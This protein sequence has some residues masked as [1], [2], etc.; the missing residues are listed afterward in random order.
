MLFRSLRGRVVQLNPWDLIGKK[1]VA[2][3]K[4]KTAT[5]QFVSRALTL[6]QWQHLVEGLSIDG[7]EQERRLL[8][9]LWLGFGCGLRAAEML[10]LTMASLVPSRDAWQLRVLGKGSK[11]RTVPLPSPARQALLAYL[12]SVGVPYED[13]VRLALEDSVDSEAPILRGMRGRRRRIRGARHSRLQPGGG[14]QQRH[15]REK[16]RS[17]MAHGC[18]PVRACVPSAR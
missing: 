3:A 10:S 6:E 15:A 16:H 5:E 13:V 17:E 8:L 1:L 9:I 4:L 12:D 11:V 18:S 14:G 2:R 7:T